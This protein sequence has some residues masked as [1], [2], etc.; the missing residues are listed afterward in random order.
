M[1]EIVRFTALQMNIILL[2]DNTPFVIIVVI[3]FI[4]LVLFALLRMTGGKYFVE[5]IPAV[6]YEKKALKLWLENSSVSAGSAML[7][8]VI[9]F[10]NVCVLFFE[11]IFIR[12]IPAHPSYVYII[13]PGMVLGYFVG[14]YLLYYL[15]GF[16]TN[17]MEATAAYV[18]G[19]MIIYRVFGVVLFPVIISLPFCSEILAKILLVVA[20][21]MFTSVQLLIWYRTIITCTKTKFSIFYLFLYLC[22]LEILPILFIFKISLSLM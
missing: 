11:L 22:T 16:I 21:A 7:L 4:S 5:T 3:T 2:P 14:K 15:I 8:N 19:I 9:L 12:K 10:F 6:I 1:L 17:Q 18:H 20:V 13:V